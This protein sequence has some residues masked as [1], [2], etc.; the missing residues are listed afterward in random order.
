LD[1]IKTMPELPGHFQV[2]Q[3][4]TIK[5]DDERKR[6][7]LQVFLTEKG[8]MSKVYFNPVH[9]KTIYSSAYGYHAGD[10]P[11][12]EELSRTVL[13]LPMY[14]RMTDEDIAY[15]VGAMREFFEA[16]R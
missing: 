14:A 3:M 5:L 15:L 7:A 16:E 2:Y 6:D 9:L 13:T 10:L 8:I 12:T 1:G 11:V 4:Y